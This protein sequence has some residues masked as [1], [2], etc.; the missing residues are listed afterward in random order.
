VV[1]VCGSWDSS[2]LLYSVNSACVLGARIS[3]AHDDSVG[4][5]ST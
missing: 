2:L 3:Q 5:A 4:C 1:V